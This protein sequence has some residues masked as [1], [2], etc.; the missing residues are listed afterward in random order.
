M[1]AADRENFRRWFAWL[2]ESQF[3]R[4]TKDLPAEV[5]DCAALARFAYREA[6]RRHDGRWAG[7]LRLTDVPPL[8][9]VRGYGKPAGGWF[10]IGDGRYADFADARTLMRE[11]TSLIAREL[12]RAAPGDLLFYHQLEQDMPFHLMIYLGEHIVYH[13]GPIGGGP[14]EV[15][16]PSVQELRRHPDPRWRPVVGNSNFL[17]VFRWHILSEL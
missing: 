17:G 9:P 16:R 1:D 8:G 4:E 7:E 10:H 11:N 12:E 13:T 6:L 14:G 15:R 3:Y 5:N 2:A